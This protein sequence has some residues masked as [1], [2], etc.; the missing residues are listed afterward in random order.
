MAQVHL[1]NVFAAC[2]SKLEPRSKLPVFHLALQKQL[3]SRTRS[4]S[5]SV[6]VLII[7]TG[8]NDSNVRIW[9][10]YFIRLSVMKKFTAD[11]VFLY[12]LWLQLVLASSFHQLAA[13]S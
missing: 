2:C 11:V 7:F 3:V 5:P 4:H 1:L 8:Y 10:I 6:L 12:L 9:Q 13:S